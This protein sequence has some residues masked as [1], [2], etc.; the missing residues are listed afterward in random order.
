MVRFSVN[1]FRATKA[2]P[3]PSYQTKDS[4]RKLLASVRVSY[5]LASAIFVNKFR[6]RRQLNGFSWHSWPNV[7]STVCPTITDGRAEKNDVRVA[8]TDSADISFIRTWNDDQKRTCPAANSP[9]VLSSN[10]F[11]HRLQPY[12]CKYSSHKFTSTDELVWETAVEEVNRARCS[13][14]RSV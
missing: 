7:P 1:V 2:A 13:H 4:S 9:E 11:H 12:S 6:H 8:Q 5:L 10:Q 14:S 3:V